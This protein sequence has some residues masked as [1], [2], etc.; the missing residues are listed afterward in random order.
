MCQTNYLIIE[1][2]GMPARQW[3]EAQKARQ[4]EL[5]HTWKPWQHST[6]AKTPEGKA[7][8]SKNAVN[9]SVREVMRELNRTNRQLLVYVR[10]VFAG[11]DTSECPPPDWNEVGEQM[12][13]LH[14]KVE[15]AFV[16]K[17]YG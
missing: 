7:V 10:A 2:G 1:G 9:Y 8:S 3:T 6:G 5:I 11:L 12:E 16:Q 4:R 13:G 14:K 17:Q 15:Q